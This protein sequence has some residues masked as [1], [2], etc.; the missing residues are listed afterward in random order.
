MVLDFIKSSGKI[1]R[2]QAYRLLT[3]M[4]KKGM[5]EKVGESSRTDYYVKKSELRA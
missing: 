4:C 3:K 5:L 2:A 1:T